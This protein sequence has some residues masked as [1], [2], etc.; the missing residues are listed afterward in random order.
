M[1]L[2]RDPRFLRSADALPSECKGLLARACDLSPVL[3]VKW[4]CFL[5]RLIK[6]WSELEQV[7]LQTVSESEDVST[8]FGQ[9]K[10]DNNSTDGAGSLLRQAADEKKNAGD[11]VQLDNHL[12]PFRNSL[13]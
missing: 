8:F 6:Y 4:V 13:Y 5:H 3:L 12:A 1:A 7:H 2:L 9:L 11:L 10:S